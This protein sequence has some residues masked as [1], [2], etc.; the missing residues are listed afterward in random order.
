MTTNAELYEQDFF[1]WTQTTAA[2]IRARKWQAIDPPGI[3][4]HASI[5][6]VCRHDSRIMSPTYV[7]HTVIGGRNP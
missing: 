7:S 5:S 4:N 3:F 6:F 2:L 1:E